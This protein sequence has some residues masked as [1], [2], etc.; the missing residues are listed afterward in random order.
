L[1][2]I[3]TTGL[4]GRSNAQYDRIS[5]PSV[6]GTKIR[7]PMVGVTGD[8]GEG[9]SNLMISD[10]SWNLVSK[11][12]EENEIEGISGKFGEGTSA[13][14]RRLQ[15]AIQ[16]VDSEV[17]GGAKLKVSSLLKKIISNPFSRSIHV[18]NLAHNSVRFHLGIDKSPSINDEDLSKDEILKIWRERWLAP[19]MS[20]EIDGVESAIQKVKNCNIDNLLPPFN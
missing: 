7:F 12:I 4:Y 17:T 2:A 15:K 10:R 6:G 18:A 8:K 14:I 19:L 1:S 20:R 11:Y 13:R 5:I 3:S 16:L 9:P